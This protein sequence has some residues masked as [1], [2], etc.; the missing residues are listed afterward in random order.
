MLGAAYVRILVTTEI[1]AI[2]EPERA[3]ISGDEVTDSL[4]LGS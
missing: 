2:G 4:K 3:A 1:Q